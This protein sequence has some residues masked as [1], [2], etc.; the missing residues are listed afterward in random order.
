MQRKKSI[1]IGRKREQKNIMTSS[2]VSGR[3]PDGV[4][5]K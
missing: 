5:E 2:L 3:I 1:E 4:K